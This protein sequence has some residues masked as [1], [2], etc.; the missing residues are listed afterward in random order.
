MRQIRKSVRFLPNTEE[1]ESGKKAF[2]EALEA[3]PVLLW[4]R[5]VKGKQEAGEVSAFVAWVSLHPCKTPLHT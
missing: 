4:Q 3:A 2:D 5:G 1:K